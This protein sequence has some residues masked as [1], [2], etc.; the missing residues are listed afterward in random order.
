MIEDFAELYKT[1]L[2]CPN[3]NRCDKEAQGKRCSELVDPGYIGPGYRK[4]G[5]L[6]VAQNPGCPKNELEEINGKIKEIRDSKILLIKKFEEMMK[7]YLKEMK[8]WTIW[9][10]LKKINLEISYDKMPKIAYTNLV[11]CAWS[12]R[13]RRNIPPA[14]QHFELCSDWMRKQIEILTPELIIFFGKGAFEQAKS[15]YAFD[16]LMQR[17]IKAENWIYHPSRLVNYKRKNVKIKAERQAKNIEIL[18]Q[19]SES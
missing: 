7:E 15:I 16:D 3:K 5:I 8:K 19:R 9:K 11:K 10:N 1:I 18:L 12:S 2:N 13:S 6:I 17:Y 14:K 4:G